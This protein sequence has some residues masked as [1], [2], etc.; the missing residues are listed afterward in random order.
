MDILLNKEKFILLYL[1]SPNLG[2]SNLGLSNLDSPNLDSHNLDSPNLGLSNLDSSNLD[3]SNNELINYIIDLLKI[4]II[5]ILSNNDTI[6]YNNEMIVELVPDDKL[7]YDLL[8]NCQFIIYLSKFQKSNII[9]S[10]YNNNINNNNNKLII[11]NIF[12]IKEDINLLKNNYSLLESI[13]KNDII[14][15]LNY[16]KNLNKIDTNISYNKNISININKVINNNDN[17]I[18]IV[19]VFKNNENNILKII[20]LKCII[21]NINNKNIGNILIIGNDLNNILNE[22]INQYGDKIIIYNKDDNVSY[23]DILEIIHLRIKNNSIVFLLMSDIIIPNQDSLNNLNLDLGLVNKKEVY[24]ISRFDRI[25]N[26]NII[27]SQRLNKLFNSTEQDAWIFETPLVLNNE[28]LNRLSNVYFYDYL[29]NLYFNNEINNNHY[30]LINNTKKYKIIRFMLDN[31]INNRPLI[32]KDI[33]IKN[34]MIDYNSIHL[35]PSNDI[36]DNISIEQLIKMINLDEN[37]IYSIKCFL[38]NK[39]LKNK[40]MDNI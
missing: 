34:N 40:I 30:I 9:E 4:K 20:Q 36:I 32:D 33:N 29:S 11:Y 21:E 35:L 5:I 7:E 13:D 17:K 19:T 37:D 38:F 22:I 8:S 28:S 27:K 26:G 31:Q 24:S 16:Y 15:F 14:Y 6:Y 10:F 1:D 23:K 25:L 12:N 2:L 3:S 18:T 39:F